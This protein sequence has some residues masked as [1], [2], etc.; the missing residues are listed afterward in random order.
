MPHDVEKRL[1][2]DFLRYLT[3]PIN[4]DGF[5]DAIDSALARADGGK[6]S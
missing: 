4:I 3:K 2:P 6:A 1:A 5:T